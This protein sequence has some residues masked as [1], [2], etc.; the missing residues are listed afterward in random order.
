VSVDEVADTF[1]PAWIVQADEA[2]DATTRFGV[3]KALMGQS[4][5]KSC[6]NLNSKSNGPAWTEIATKYSGDATAPAKLADKIRGGGKGVWG[7]TNMPAHPGLTVAE[8]RSIVD[9]VLNVKSTSINEKPLTGTFSSQGSTGSAGSAG[10]KVILRAVYTDKGAGDLMAHT[11][12]AVAVRRSPTLRASSA[13]ETSGMT[14]RMEGNGGVE[15]MAAK[16]N[17]YLV[18]RNLDLTGIREV[19]IAAQAPAREGFKGGTIE[20]R[21]GSLV[22]EL[23]GQVTIG[24][25]G[26]VS[27]DANAAQ[28]AG[29][30]GNIGQAAGAGAAV[31]P[32]RNATGQ[33]DLFVVVRNFSAKADEPVL[34][35]T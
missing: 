20:V 32:L 21:L 33:R 3:A 27:P 34:S 12:E 11:V 24:N 5:C 19:H 2:V 22:G 10:S 18:F 31:I 4:D 14:A 8:A 30:A 26:V 9:Y 25:A 23:I 17:G 28:Q 16:P 15:T 7:E 29:G 13:D 1:D 6:H 35:I